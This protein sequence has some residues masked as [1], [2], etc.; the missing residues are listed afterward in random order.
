MIGE[1]VGYYSD[2]V[3]ALRVTL[4]VERHEIGSEYVHMCGASPGKLARTGES[5]THRP[6][7]MGR[8]VAW[9]TVVTPPPHTHT[10][11]LYEWI[12]FE[13]LSKLREQ[14]CSLHAVFVL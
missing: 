6:S 2:C 9:Y 14:T 8:C 3:N 10:H 11:V 13:I 12:A 5:A 4:K 7:G 1:L